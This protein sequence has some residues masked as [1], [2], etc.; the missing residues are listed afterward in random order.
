MHRSSCAKVAAQ[1]RLYAQKYHFFRRSAKVANG[2]DL[3]FAPRQNVNHNNGAT[4]FSLSERWYFEKMFC[5]LRG[6]K[7][8]FSNEWMLY[9]DELP[10]FGRHS[11]I[12][13]KSSC[14]VV[15]C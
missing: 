1:L 12:V 7:W 11:L 13:R 14:L 8:M 2:V 4:L 6:W 5:Y 15:G 3:L 10:R 9:Y